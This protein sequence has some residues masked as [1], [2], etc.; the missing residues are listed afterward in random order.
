M[1]VKKTFD[2]KLG[3]RVKLVESDEQGTIIGRAHYLDVNPQYLVRYKDANG[4][5]LECW[6]HESAVV[7]IA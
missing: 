6:W 5:L 2:F 4:H 3:I 7:A 1:A